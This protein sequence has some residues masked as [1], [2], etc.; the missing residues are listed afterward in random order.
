MKRSFLTRLEAQALHGDAN[1]P[2]N[3]RDNGMG[4]TDVERLHA[5]LTVAILFGGKVLLPIKGETCHFQMRLRLG[6]MPEY[7]PASVL[8]PP[9]LNK[10]EDGFVYA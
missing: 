4:H 5:P 7:A 2:D 6:L 8:C 9:M 10:G 1:D 3:I